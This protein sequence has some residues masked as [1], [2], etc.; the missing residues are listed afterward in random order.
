MEQ[1]S[2]AALFLLQAA[3]K[4]NKELSVVQT[5]SHS[6]RN[7]HADI[8]NMASHLAENTVTSMKP[9]RQSP[10]FK[11]LTDS[12]WE[13]MSTGWLQEVMQ[14]NICIKRQILRLM[15]L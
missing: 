13:K 7:A 5:T 8:Q 12:G 1:V 2:L 6:V 14:K 3:K 11:D 4:A 10:P 15:K 9:Q